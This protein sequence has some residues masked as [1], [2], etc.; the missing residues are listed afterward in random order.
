MRKQPPGVAKMPPPAASGVARAATVGGSSKRPP[1][2]SVLSPIEFESKE[3]QTQKGWN[4][5][6]VAMCNRAEDWKVKLLIESEPVMAEEKNEE[7][8][9][10]LHEALQTQCD[11]KALTVLILK[12]GNAIKIPNN[13]GELPLHLACERSAPFRIIDDMVQVFPDA[14]KTQTLSY[15]Q[16]PLHY[17]IRSRA[18]TLPIIQLLLKA[19]PQAAKIRDRYGR[20]PFMLGVDAEAPE[21]V[22]KALYDAFPPAAGMKPTEET[23]S[24]EFGATP[25]LSSAESGRLSRESPS[26]QTRRGSPKTL[27][28]PLLAKFRN[29]IMEGERIE[30]Q[31]KLYV[32]HGFRLRHNHNILHVALAKGAPIELV[33]FILESSPNMA[34]E[35]TIDGNNP[36]MEGLSS[37]ANEEA[38]NAVLDAYGSESCKSV[39]NNNEFALHL[40]VRKSS[41]QLVLRILREN[42][43]ATMEQ[44]L[45]EDEMPLHRLMASPHSDELVENILSGY[46]MAARSTDKFS[47]TPLHVAMNNRAPKETIL[48]VFGAFPEAL[49]IE[50]IQGRTPMDDSKFVDTL[51]QEFFAYTRREYEIACQRRGYA[52]NDILREYKPRSLHVNRG[53]NSLHVA[54]S[55]GASPDKI[56]VLL[57]TSPNMAKKR[58]DSGNFPLN[59]GLLGQAD[60]LSLGDV[61]IAF[62]DACKVSNNDGEYALHHATFS[63]S[64]ICEYVL[65]TYPD[66]IDVAATLSKAM[67]LHVLVGQ[68]E[69]SVRIE[70]IRLLV[71]EISIKSRD[72]NGDTPLHIAIKNKLHQDEIEYLLLEFAEGASIADD[73]GHLPLHSAI[74]NELPEELLLTLLKAYPAA[75]RM[76]YEDEG[77]LPLHLAMKYRSGSAFTT[78]LISENDKAPSI[79][80]KSGF[81]PLSLAL[82]YGADFGSVFTLLNLYRDAAKI[83]DSEGMVPLHVAMM[84]GAPTMIIMA[85]IS[86]YP[87]AISY[88]NSQ[89]HTPFLSGIV[90]A[91][92]VL[93]ERYPGF[94]KPKQVRGGALPPKSA[95]S[96]ELGKGSGPLSDLLGLLSNLREMLDNAREVA[97]QRDAD[98]NLPLLQFCMI[99]NPSVIRL[100]QSV[101]KEA[102]EGITKTLNAIYQAF[103]KAAEISGS[104]VGTPINV[105]VGECSLATSI[106]QLLDHEALM[107]LQIVLENA[108]DGRALQTLC[109]TGNKVSLWA[110][111]SL[112]DENDVL[113]RSSQANVGAAGTHPMPHQDL[114]LDLN[115]EVIKSW[116][117][118]DILADFDTPESADI[119]LQILREQ[120]TK[121]D[122]DN[123][124]F[125]IVDEEE[126]TLVEFK[127]SHAVSDAVRTRIADRAK[128]VNASV[129]L[130]KWGEAYGRFLKRYRL[131]KQPKHVSE[132]CVVVFGTEAVQED[133]GKVNEKPVALKFMCLRDTFLREVKKRPQNAGGNTDYVVPIR[134]T[135]SSSRN[136]EF[137]CTQVDLDTELEPYSDTI[138]LEGAKIK[139][140][141]VMDCGAGYD[142]HDFI[143]HQNVAGK[144]L[145]TVTAIAKEIALCLKFLNEK[146]R[147]IHGDVKARNFVAK[148]VGRIGFA[149][150]DLDNA[151]SIGRESAGQKR[152]SSGYLPPEQAAVEAYD[153]TGESSNG[154][155]RAPVVI[156]SCQY[157]MWCFG[158]LLYFLCTGKQLFNVDTK[159]DVD[160]EDLMRIRDWDSDWKREKL[161][162]VDAKWPRRLL[163]SLLQKDPANRPESW[164]NI[165]DE[166]NR[167]TSSRDN[168]VYDRIVIFQSAPLVYTRR[169]DNQVVPMEQL[170]FNQES[171]MLRG[172][173]KDAEQ[174]GC[175]IDAMLETGS[176]DRLQAFMAQQMSSVLHYSGHGTDDYMA[177]EDERGKLN[178]FRETELRRQ[179]KD[180]GTFLKCA[181]ISACHSE[182]VAKAFVEAGV[183]HAICCP[184][185]EMLQDIA[186][187][188][189]T[190][191]FYRSLACKNTIK[192]AF[193]TAKRTVIDSPFVTNS[194]VEAE[195]FLLLPEMPEDPDYHEVQIFYTSEITPIP[196]ESNTCSI[197]GVPRSRDLLEGRNVL[198]YS[199][200][201]NLAPD[202]HT[203]VLRVFGREGLGKTA[204]VA[205]V[206]RHI[207][208][209]PRAPPQL[210]Y[211]Y[212][213]PPAGQVGTVDPFY[214]CISSYLRLSI[215]GREGN[216]G[217][218]PELMQ[219]RRSIGET[220]DQKSLLLIID[221]REYQYSCKGAAER[222]FQEAISQL[223]EMSTAAYFK[224]ILI[225]EKP[226]T[227]NNTANSLREEPVPV[228]EVEIDAAIKLFARRIPDDLRRKYPELNNSNNL[229][230]RVLDPPEGVIVDDNVLADREDEVWD[231]YLGSGKPGRCCDI[232][233]DSSSA[234]IQKLL[235]PWWE[236]LNNVSLHSAAA[237]P[238]DDDD[239]FPS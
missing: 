62:P 123:E 64:T 208:L 30:E 171:N 201:C 162:K 205:D 135:Y 115:K 155:H 109:D 117:I 152:T 68:R 231:R 97:E 25:S 96:S 26:N 224:V 234:D 210:D 24:L 80:T 229:V 59:E 194:A 141:I 159:E 145:L 66:A 101:Q 29:G 233:R 128:L 81:T 89:G 153:R 98:G 193:L 239:D 163:D 55:R 27:P 103:P 34:T 12:G 9:T 107:R 212:W 16:T 69:R 92:H 160:D 8:N 191:S 149:A 158:V 82:T 232:A 219:L 44:S 94:F 83:R 207:R 53:W 61:L 2:S 156:A 230:Q 132:S 218:N 76:K 14:V 238:R 166:L 148:G 154:E 223:L 42:R 129:E 58:N 143:S 185:D 35:K 28:A 48:A 137:E 157:D 197:V 60:S 134:K 57:Q 90:P 65:T 40:A 206:C 215:E 78:A 112:F 22:L 165:V 133:A 203:D 118:L 4:P 151:S 100:G 187:S 23:S 99:F 235:R 164:S 146:C 161:A 213:F 45:G 32:P 140:V 174:V 63:N 138:K 119:L 202:S 136:D 36:L 70:D 13:Q 86:A 121:L 200:L 220:E 209:R 195:K 192:Q 7:G 11:F 127:S 108:R 114:V 67:P 1:A 110:L 113:S 222:V 104:F 122:H 227:K 180:I 52:I 179:I 18:A 186:A 199:I 71:T 237:V 91:V 130:R 225:D 95:S 74:R 87:D 183:P 75:V 84:K 188:E 39:N 15:H 124:I 196:E 221:L 120:K 211:M 126:E 144:D 236:E 50:D 21:D 216:K 173:L 198:K 41:P 116:S 54:L 77:F 181:F 111:F 93:Q 175:T 37:G 125:R 85:L 182:W 38:L 190:R 184:V 79:K 73:F 17:L 47:R 150:I 33:R 105:L 49:G 56:E 102:A 46:R 19:C 176:P 214:E 172:A 43:D 72:A 10:P 5:L 178:P 170:D 167:L 169:I 168:V 226:P 51:P 88:V 228:C 204:L 3:W 31:L 139:Y 189:F 217:E 131:E 147:I 142:L 177:W 20:T 6:H 106:E